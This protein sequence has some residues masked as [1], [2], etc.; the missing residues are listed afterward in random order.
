MR[1]RLVVDGAGFEDAPELL[2]EAGVYHRPLYLGSDKLLIAA[3]PHLVDLYRERR[4]ANSMAEPESD[5]AGD[6]SDAALEAEANRVAQRMKDA[7]AAGDETGG[8]LLPSDQSELENADSGADPRT[9]EAA[10]DRLDRVVAALGPTPFVVFWV[11]EREMS[12]AVLFKHLRTLNKVLIPNSNVEDGEDAPFSDETPPIGEEKASVPEPAE[13]AGYEA[14]LFRH[15]DGN[16]LAQVLPA[17]E[18]T[19]LS[20]IFGPSDILLYASPDYPSPSGQR[21]TRAARAA[22][23]PPAPPGMMKLSKAEIERIELRRLER[24]VDSRVK[25]NVIMRSGFGRL[26][27]VL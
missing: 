5:V 26:C 9:H 3:G 19:N 22:D 4:H 14:V 11:G 16:A 13:R 1:L 15:A 24:M 6:L 23:L 18:P 10:Q 17:L 2:D 21:L 8:G 12:D 20:R 7:L 27:Q 25:C